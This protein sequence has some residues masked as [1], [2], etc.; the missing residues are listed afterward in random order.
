MLQIRANMGIKEKGDGK[1]RLFYP[2]FSHWFQFQRE[3]AAQNRVSHDDLKTRK[4]MRASREIGVLK[5]V[6][7]ELK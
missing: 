2:F 5:E 6:K 3:I 1:K 7:I 4:K